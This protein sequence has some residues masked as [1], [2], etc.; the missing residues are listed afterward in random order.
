MDNKQR[1]AMFAKQGSSN[2]W[3]PSI[4]RDEQYKHLYDLQKKY[5]KTFGSKWHPNVLDYEESIRGER[6]SLKRAIDNADYFSPDRSWT[7][8]KKPIHIVENNIGNNR[9]IEWIEDRLNIIDTKKFKDHNGIEHELEK[10][11]KEYT[12]GYTRLNPESLLDIAKFA[13][14]E[15]LLDE[16]K[17]SELQNKGIFDHNPDTPISPVSIKLSNNTFI[18]APYVTG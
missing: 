5:P 14:K 11:I 1:K 4:T 2:V 8:T 15:G 18:V 7:F 13:K 10:P 17:I 9:R 12:V 16:G 6:Y 3:K